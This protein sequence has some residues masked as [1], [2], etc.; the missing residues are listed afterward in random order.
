MKLIT[1]PEPLIIEG[2]SIFLAGSIDQDTAV[3]WQQAVISLLADFNVT[4]LNPR[5]KAW[6]ASWTED[7]PRFIEQ[8]RWE[9]AALKR[10]TWIMMHFEPGT[11]SPIT[12]LEFGQY[13]NS[14]KLFVS[15]P[16]GFWRRGNVKV[17]CA[18]AGIQLHD[19]V[20]SLTAKLISQL[21]LIEP[22]RQRRGWTAY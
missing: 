22:L 7:D 9:Q 19:S 2:L 21:E 8:V 16:K 4:V 13:G 6:D 12:L 18:D 1:A 15:C 5:R 14:G 11:L 20:Q 17:L 3:D 10:A